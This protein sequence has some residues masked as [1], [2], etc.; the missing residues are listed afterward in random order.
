MKLISLSVEEMR[1]FVVRCL[2]HGCRGA[3]GAR[4][5][6]KDEPHPSRAQDLEHVR[7][8]GC[9]LLGLWW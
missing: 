2:G 7:A 9:R 4:R 5:H 6:E 8:A 3:A 1:I